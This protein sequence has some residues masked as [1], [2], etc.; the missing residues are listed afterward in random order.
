MLKIME[1]CD[2]FVSETKDVKIN[3]AKTRLHA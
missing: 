2:V 1:V 3:T